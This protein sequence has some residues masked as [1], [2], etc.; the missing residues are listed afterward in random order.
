MKSVFTRWLSEPL[1]QFLVLGALIFAADA[2][3]NS[4][5]SKNNRTIRV[6]AQHIDALKAAYQAEHSRLPSDA[7]LQVRL[8]QWLD[9]QILYQEARALG[10][11]QRD[12]IVRR[13]MVQKMRFLLADAMPLAEPGEAELQAF[14]ENHAERYGH[15][16]RLSFEQV[17]LSRGGRGDQMGE[18][19]RQVLKHLQASPD[20]FQGQG[21]AFATGQVVEAFDEGDVRREFGRDFYP[22]IVSLP[23]NEW[24]GPVASSLGLHMVRITG[25]NDFRPAQLSEVR[26]KVENDW[27]V[28]QR[29]QI[30]AQAMENLRKRFQIEYEGRSSA[31]SG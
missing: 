23:D 22:R 9:E 20:D 14:L 27:R 7:E 13:Q 10:L 26:A 3:L 15:S 4:D 16:P 25:R 21:D 17:F 29:E 2:L 12:S 31:G 5:D 11:D 8:Q 6:T 28:D 19:V 18:S 24:Q 30:N 1:I